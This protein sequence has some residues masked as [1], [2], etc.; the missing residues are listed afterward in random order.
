MTRTQQIEARIEVLRAQASLLLE[1][2][3]VTQE[4]LTDINNKLVVEEKKLETEN[5]INTDIYARTGKKLDNKVAKDEVTEEEY[6]AAVYNALRNKTTAQEREIL[7]ARNA[8]SSFTG[9]DGGYLLPIDQVTAINELKRSLGSLR[10]HVTVEP[11]NTKSGSRVL[12]KDADYVAFGIVDENSE[13][14]D[15]T[16]PKFETVNYDVKDRGG[17]LPVPNN[18]LNDSNQNVKAYLNRWLAKKAVATENDIIVATLEKF[19]KTPIDDIDSIKDALDVTLDPAISLQAE[20]V[21]N[22]DS[23]NYLNKLKD[24]DGNYIL[25]RDPKNPTKKILAGRPVTIYSNKVLK[26]KAGKAPILIGSLKEAVMLFDRQA[27]SILAT[28]IGGKAFQ[29]NRTEI[30]AIMRMDAQQF[31]K[32]AIVYGEITL[33]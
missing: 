20:I 15:T 22:Q 26:T 3:G 8:L 18:L 29:T 19:P 10:E 23:F 31:D 5:R 14:E 27:I 32:T 24:S 13:I 4:E 28:N 21:V 6:S 7:T 1:K 25:E 9:E 16:T 33:I 30:R 12:E 2:E 17:I 11:V